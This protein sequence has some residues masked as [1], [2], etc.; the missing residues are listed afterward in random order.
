MPFPATVTLRAVRSG[1]WSGC[2][3]QVL[4]HASP[5]VVLGRSPETDV[6]DTR[7]SRQHGR[8]CF[9]VL[10]NRRTSTQRSS[11]SATG[12]QKRLASTST[13]TATSDSAAKRPKQSTS[14][15]LDAL[16]RTTTY[17]RLHGFQLP[18]RPGWHCY[19]DSVL[20]KLFG[21]AP[22][23]TN[24]RVAAFDFDG[25]LVHT[26]VANR[27]PK[28]WSLRV[29]EVP[30]VLQECHAAGYQI[31]IITNESLARFKKREPI[32]MNLVKKTTRLDEFCSRL[33]MPLVVGLA[34]VWENW[35]FSAR[36]SQYS[37]HQAAWPYELPKPN[38][39]YRKPDAGMWRMLRQLN[40]CEPDLSDSFY[41][42]DAAGRP[43]DHSDSDKAFAQRV[44]LRFLTESEFFPQ[45]LAALPSST[46]P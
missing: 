41:V 27:D 24:A 23:T 33:D 30:R 4:S 31:A 18:L 42:G 6:R 25:C 11:Q 35:L 7:C 32:E 20:C 46:A 34:V 22:P 28:A 29:P 13:N 39:Q 40:A 5:E 2:P 9:E 43:R 10:F 1:L 8:Y 14:V 36:F 21:G 16:G 3:D 17:L 12:S 37:A 26:S 15:A 19:Q 45:G 44:G 38:D